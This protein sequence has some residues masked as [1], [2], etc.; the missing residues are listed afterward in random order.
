VS[1]LRC[2]ASTIF[3]GNPSILFDVAFDPEAAALAV[4]ESLR[5]LGTPERA[6]QEKRY[7]KSDLEFLGVTVPDLRKAV[8]WAAREIAKRDPAWVAEWTEARMAAMSGVTFTEAVRRL[9]P[10]EA[11]RLR[12]ERAAT[13]PRKRLGGLAFATGVG[14]RT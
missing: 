8:G 14:L 3:G 2:E 11:A 4:A 9:P 5:P 12:A 10:P 7:L 1:H 6:A 13:F